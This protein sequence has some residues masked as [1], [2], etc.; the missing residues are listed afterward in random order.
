MMLHYTVNKSI[1]FIFDYLTD[2]KKFVSVHPV[3][4]RMEPLGKNRFIVYETLKLGFI[5]FSFS[6]PAT[7]SSYY[8]NAMVVVTITVMKL[9]NIEMTF[10]LR[11]EEQFSIVEEKIN[12]KTILPIRLLLQKIL[13]KQHALLFDN[14][15][16][17]KE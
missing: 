4:T 12:F 6:Y 3:I 9:I 14:I 13:K 17:S 8:Q 2:V 7:V 5:C 10:N 15:S 16:N 11:Q 1:S